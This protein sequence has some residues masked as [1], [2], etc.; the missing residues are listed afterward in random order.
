MNLVNPDYWH[1]PSIL[2]DKSSIG[3]PVVKQ[4]EWE[5]GWLKRGATTLDRNDTVKE[6]EKELQRRRK[7]QEVLTTEGVLPERK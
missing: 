1:L 3:C 7:D 6:V 2:S 5:L 4:S